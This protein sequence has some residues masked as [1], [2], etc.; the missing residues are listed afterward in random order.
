MILAIVNYHLDIVDLERTNPGSLHMCAKIL[1]CAMMQYQ[2]N[3]VDEM[4]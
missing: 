2:R 3:S 4:I 1:N